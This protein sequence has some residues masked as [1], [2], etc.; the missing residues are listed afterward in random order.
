MGGRCCHLQRTSF[1]LHKIRRIVRNFTRFKIADVKCNQ[2][3]MLYLHH[4]LSALQH[5]SF[6]NP[7]GTSDTEWSEDLKSLI[8]WLE[9]ASDMI[10][11]HVTV[12]IHNIYK[13]RD[14]K[15][16]A[17]QICQAAAAFIL[18]WGLNC[19]LDVDEPIP[20]GYVQ[21]DCVQLDRY[22]CYVL[23]DGSNNLNGTC[24]EVKSEWERVRDALKRLKGEHR[25]KIIQPLKKIIQYRPPDLLFWRVDVDQRRRWPYARSVF[26]KSEEY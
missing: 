17:E 22:I 21:E 1:Q 5:C 23:G 6:Q 2:R 13:T 19:F 20:E 7:R 10:R 11:V 26:F 12:D 4:T 15:V 3:I 9:R 18:N 16:L 24:E 25:Q 8:W 14:A